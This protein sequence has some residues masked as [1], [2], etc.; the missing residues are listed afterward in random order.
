MARYSEDRAASRFRIAETKKRLTQ[1]V[2][3]CVT[4]E[5]ELTTEEVVMALIELT[6]NWQNRLIDYMADSKS[7]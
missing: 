1:E 3:N 6:S 4:S 5:P 7:S 2:I